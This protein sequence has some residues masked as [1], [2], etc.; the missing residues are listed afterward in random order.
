[1]RV[2]AKLYDFAKGTVRTEAREI[3]PQKILE[4]NA[5]LRSI[6]FKEPH[7]YVQQ[8]N[9][10]VRHELR[11]GNWVETAHSRLTPPDEA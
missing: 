6:A 9:K 1:M 3:D 7:K 2:E 11:D 5:L 8:G 10:W 4:G